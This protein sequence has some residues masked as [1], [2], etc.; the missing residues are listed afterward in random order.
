[1]EPA[2]L[3]DTLEALI[4]AAPQPPSRQALAATLARMWAGEPEATRNARLQHVQPALLLLRARWA[5]RGG[6]FALVDVADGLAFRTRAAFAEVLRVAREG[7]PQKLSKP[8]LETLAIVAYRQ[9]VTKPE[10]D[11]IRGVDCAGT[12]KVLLDRELV[13]IV[14][15]KEEPGRPLCYGTTRAFL[16]L[17]SLANLQ[18]LPS[19]R[20]FVELSEASEQAVESQFGPSLTELSQSAAKVGALDE[21]AMQDLDQAMSSLSTTEQAARDGFQREGIHLVPDAG[22]E[23]NRH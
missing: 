13:R 19:L 16:N 12:F 21:P 22:E 9:P 6:G 1:M 11:H 2:D 14:G 23:D 3:V 10:A 5:E 7:R 18:A 8:A 20:D 4:F 17:F 15:K